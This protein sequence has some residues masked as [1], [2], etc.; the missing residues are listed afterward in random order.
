MEVF[1]F[2]KIEKSTFLQVFLRLCK[3]YKYVGFD[4]FEFSK[5]FIIIILFYSVDSLPFNFQK[6]T[7]ISNLPFF[8]LKM[9]Q[10]FCGIFWRSYVKVC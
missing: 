6:R 8:F 1:S 10:V 5:S 9:Y 3:N 2:G 4:Y 7:K